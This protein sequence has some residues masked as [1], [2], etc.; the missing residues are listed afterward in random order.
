MIVDDDEAGR[1]DR[2]YA[3]DWRDWEGWCAKRGFRAQSATPET[4]ALYLRS[5]DNAGRRYST[6]RRRL[7]AINQ[8][9]L[10]AGLPV[11]G[12]DALVRDVLDDIRDFQTLA[13]IGKTPLLTAE[14]RR[15]LAALPNSVAGI[16]DRALLLVGFAGGLRRSELVALDVDDVERQPDGILL[17]L[18]A[19]TRQTRRASAIEL[20][21]Q[22]EP[23]T[24]AVR[25]AGDWLDRSGLSAGPLFRS[26]N[27]HGQ[28]GDGRM[29]DKAVALI[30]KRAAEGA[31]LD[32]ARYAANSLRSGAAIERRLAG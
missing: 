30:V 32:P 24:C 4:V 18:R 6:I 9:Q 25:A 1:T 19:G 15:I 10:V 16:R 23:E 13:Q 7:A 22:P 14:L 2:A 21:R 27:R 20:V 11:P 3:T 12:R 28:L 29:S 17:R 26:I 5:L 8:R 31:G